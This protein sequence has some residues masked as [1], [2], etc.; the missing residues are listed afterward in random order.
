MAFRHVDSDIKV[1]TTSRGCVKSGDRGRVVP[2][3]DAV[4][5]EGGNILDV[6]TPEETLDR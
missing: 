6:L 4:H 1:R 2:V 3:P 5:L